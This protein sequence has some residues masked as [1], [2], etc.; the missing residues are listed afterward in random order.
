MR[1]L[2]AVLASLMFLAGAAHAA[3]PTAGDQYRV[4]PEPQPATEKSGKVEVIEFFSY[5]CPH[6]F[7]FHPLLTKW[8]SR[9]ADDHVLVRVPVK[10][11]RAS[12]ALLAKAYYVAETLGV[13]DKTHDALYDALHVQ[14]R[15]LDS[16]ARLVDFFAEQGVD[17]QDAADAF[18]SFAV[19]M[20]MRRAAKLVKDYGV[21]STPSMAVDGRY[22]VDP[23]TAGGQKQMLDVVDYLIDKVQKQ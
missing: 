19:D 13:L 4:L 17:R 3:T 11:G 7:D 8:E 22:I 20:K 2:T 9:H 18:D 14:G 15:R 12:W 16:K 21:R 5:A 23:S 6:C 1:L 10:F